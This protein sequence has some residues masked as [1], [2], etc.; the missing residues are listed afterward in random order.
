MEQ[1][2]EKP[3]MPLPVGGRHPA[4]DSPLLQAPH[5][6]LTPGI[7]ES[8][9]LMPGVQVLLTLC[10]HDGRE[11]C[12]IPDRPECGNQDRCCWRRPKAGAPGE[13]LGAAKGALEC[14]RDLWLPPWLGPPPPVRAWESQGVLSTH[15]SPRAASGG[16]LGTG[17][18]MRST[19]RA[20]QRSPQFSGHP[21]CTPRREQDPQ[22]LCRTKFPGEGA[23]VC[24]RECVSMRL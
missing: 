11:I 10:T 13:P 5:G 3:K 24:E 6:Y 1:G 23:R 4:P 19:L 12:E 17:K 16:I 22:E 7:M 8:C 21:C 14:V 2:S 20:G 18:G 15:S 9:A